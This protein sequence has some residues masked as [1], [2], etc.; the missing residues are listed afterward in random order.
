MTAAEARRK[1]EPF[2]PDPAFWEQRFQ[3]LD[4]EGYVTYCATIPLPAPPSS[5][6]YEE[7]AKLVSRLEKVVSE[8]RSERTRSAE[9]VSSQPPPARS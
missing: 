8:I 9:Q 7:L 2:P 4:G 6:H 1:A 3:Y 5:P